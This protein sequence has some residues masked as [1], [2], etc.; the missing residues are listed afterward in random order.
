MKINNVEVHGLERAIITSRFPMIADVEEY[1]I[2]MNGQA[3][4]QA[5][6]TLKNLANT[7]NS[8]GHNQALTG[9]TVMFDVTGSIQWWQEAERYRFLNFISS[10]SK[11]HKLSKMN[12]RNCCNK[13]TSKEAIDN[14]EFH[15]FNYLVAKAKFDNKEIEKSELDEYF[16]KMIYNIPQGF[17]YTAGMVTNYRCLRNIYGQRKNHRLQEWKDF[18]KWIESL[19]MA[20][21]FITV[22]L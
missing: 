1:L 15:K 14:A 20:E 13:Y 12:I 6:K 8:E 2:N 10:T 9:I 3:F 18:C 4:S 21:D 19:P 17:E 7:G 16:Y 11:M 22:G 5:E